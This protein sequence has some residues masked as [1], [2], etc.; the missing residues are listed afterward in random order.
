MTGAIGGRALALGLGLFAAGAP[1]IGQ[2]VTY[3]ANP[4]LIFDWESRFSAGVTL[5]DADGDGTLDVFLANGRHGPQADMVYL[6]AGNG[7]LLTA[8]QL[9]DELRPSYA[10]ATGDLD[11]DG[12]VDAVVVTDSV[13]SQVFLNDGKGSFAPAGVIQGSDGPARNGLLEDLDGDGLLDLLTVQRRGGVR[14]FA[15]K[16]D[17]SFAEA[18]ELPGELRGATGVATGDFNRDGRPDLVI[19]CRDGGASVVLFNM[20]TRGW[21]PAPISCSDGDHRQV[22]AGD[23]NRD[24]HS[25]FVLAPST[26]MSVLR[27]GDGGGK[28]V[29]AGTIGEEGRLVQALAAADLDA[30][31]DLDLVE[32]AG[33]QSNR[34]YFNDGMGRFSHITLEDE[35]EDTY[36]VAIGDMTGDGKPDLVFGNSGSPNILMIAAA[37]ESE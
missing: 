16:G 26:G 21:V 12:D 3:N 37:A 35:A 20:G 6:N 11:G 18:Q 15:G 13:P 24:G 10:I 8:R 32:A 28:F 19:A 7:R 2:S 30:D 25:D 27:L 31:G 23:F 4:F 36:G 9:G 5:A 1:A 29:T 33:E 34:V 14:L 17:G 22:V